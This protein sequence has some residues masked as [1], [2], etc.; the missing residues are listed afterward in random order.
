MIRSL[1]FATVLLAVVAPPLARA[2][3]NIDEDKTPAH[4]YDNDCAVCHKSIHGLANGRGNSALA[5]FL[6]EHYTSSKQ[7]AAALAAYVLAGG[8]GSGTPTPVRDDGSEPDHATAAGE[9]SAAGE[10]AAAGEGS[11]PHQVRRVAK[12]E[13]EHA[14]AAKPR[15]HVG[16]YGKPARPQRRTAAAE[17]GP[18]H[19]ERKLPPDRRESGPAVPAQH[20]APV[21]QSVP[22]PA[23]AASPKPE[24]AQVAATPKAAASAKPDV[25]PPVSTPSAT[26]PPATPT[27]E[28]SPAGRDNIPD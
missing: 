23:Q 25:T 22:E 5:G 20:S 21:Q 7:E 17:P 14:T 2:Q 19:R 18:T 16:D 27:G 3:V 8:G 15:R 24:S 26:P 13:E 6:A 9:G 11:K 10:G 1:V 28:G 4:I 12:P